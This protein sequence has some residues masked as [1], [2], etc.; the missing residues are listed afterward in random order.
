MFTDGE[1]TERTEREGERIKTRGE[2]GKREDAEIL[3]GK[4]LNEKK[5]SGRTGKKVRRSAAQN[6]L[7]DASDLKHYLLLVSYD[8]SGFVGWQQQTQGRTVQDV[9]TKVA[10]AVFKQSIKMDG[11]GRTDAG[12]HALRQA[13][14][15][16]MRGSLNPEKIKYVLNH[17]LPGDIRVIS[18]EEKG[19]D[20]HARYSATAKT[21]VYKIK[22]T[23]ERNVFDSRYY[24]YVE[25]P[26]DLNRMKEA[27]AYFC[28]THDFEHYSASNHGK[29]STVRTI[30]GMELS[31][32]DN[33]ISVRIRGDGFLW[34]MVRMI[35]QTLIDA[36]L[37]EIRPDEVPRLLTESGRIKEAAP[38][39]GLYME[40][41]EFQRN[42][43]MK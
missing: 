11:A 24:H 42:D 40:E 27:A 34:K 1:K 5:A 33:V 7:A 4:E 20:F 41:V 29:K 16:S 2:R 30:H 37:G 10:R 32:R 21:Y 14:S 12:V 22:N 35:V 39:C 26:L 28:G 25:R 23:E 43:H 13:V 38:A 19:A 17:S 15:F 36:G 18:A 8:G 9:L 6:R 31:S 3:K